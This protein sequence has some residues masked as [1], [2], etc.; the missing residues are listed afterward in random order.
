MIFIT[1]LAGLVGRFAGRVLN[2][3]LGW[4]TIL[5][6]GQVR[7]SRQMLLLLVTLGSLASAAALAG[8]F[9]PT[10][11]TFLIA[12]VPS[13]AFVD[14]AWIR[15]AMLAIALLLPLFVGIGGLFLV[16]AND[17]PRGRAAALAVARGYPL[18]LVLAVTLVMLSVIALWTKALSLGR[19]W[20]DAHVP[21]VLKPGGYERLVAELDDALDRWGLPVDPVAAPRALSIPG[22]LL[23]AVGGPGVRA[24]VPQR[25]L[26]LRRPDLQVLVYPSDVAMSGRRETVARARAAIAIRL[27]RAPAYLTISRE[28]E[29]VEERLGPLAASSVT[30]S[31]RAAREA[32]EDIDRRL[33]ELAVPFEEWETLYRQRLQVERDMLARGVESPPPPLEPRGPATPPQPERQRSSSWPEWAAAAVGFGLIA[34]DVGLLVLGRMSAVRDGPNGNRR[35]WPWAR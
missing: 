17:R 27:P 25:L 11:G 2:S 12:L 26:V 35:R 13:P 20:T 15:L 19:R 8:V 23:A 31:S 18:T 29:H 6:F 4:A 9:V 28:A 14:E 10:V 16:D 34:L 5:L 1:G 7:Q 30:A 22:R 33:H 21:I 3:A 24:L 32:L